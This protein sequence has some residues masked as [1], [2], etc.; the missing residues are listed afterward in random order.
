MIEQRST[1]SLHK[2][3]R[4]KMITYLEELMAKL[5]GAKDELPVPVRADEGKRPN[6]RFLKNR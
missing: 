6:D 3:E 5:F 2:V 4:L 1:G